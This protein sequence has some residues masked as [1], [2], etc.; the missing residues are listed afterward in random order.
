MGAKPSFVK[1][2]F[3]ETAKKSKSFL[4]EKLMKNGYSTQT[5]KNGCQSLAQVLPCRFKWYNLSLFKGTHDGTFNFCD[6]I[7]LLK[8]AFVKLLKGKRR[9]NQWVIIFTCT[10]TV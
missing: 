5:T 6:F 1:V 4:N 8:K 7:I 3:I 2:I 10:W 9:K